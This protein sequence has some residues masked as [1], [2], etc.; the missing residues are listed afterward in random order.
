MSTPKEPLRIACTI[1]PVESGLLPA[2]VRRFTALSRIPVDYEALGSGAALER[3][4]E[5]G[6]DLV[7]AHAPDLEE[8]F[9][10][11]GFA[12]GRHPF[13]ASTFV[14]AGPPADPAG[15]RGDDD[16]ASALRR[17]AETR[18]TFLSRG[19]RSGTHLRELDLWREAGIEPTGGIGETGEVD[20]AAEW[21][22][23]SAS[24]SR[25][26]TTVAREAARTG[27]YTLIDWT[28]LIAAGPA[29]VPLTTGDP[30]LINIFSALP[31]NPEP[32]PGF[33]AEASS[34]FLHW[35][36]DVEAQELIANFGRAEYG[37]PL[38]LTLDRVA[39]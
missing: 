19:D 12:T 37:V 7:I 38:F 3:A 32:V 20:R 30:R 24:G 13:A 28:S 4:R 21:Y 10:A 8:R 2:L 17:I 23:V 34:A 25:G 15:I 16:V 35:L 31:I 5:G 39:E 9:V 26:S 29:L 18:S 6:I 33:H 14:I 1:G 27:A 22:Q 11:D 36:L